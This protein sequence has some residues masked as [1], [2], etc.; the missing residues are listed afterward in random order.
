MLRVLGLVIAQC[1]MH[2]ETLKARMW[3]SAWCWSI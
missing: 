2:I 3:S 1:I